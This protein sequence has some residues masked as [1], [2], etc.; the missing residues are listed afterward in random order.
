[1]SGELVT[2]YISVGTLLH[3]WPQVFKRISR[4]ERLQ[5]TRN[6]RVVASLSPPDRD[7]VLLDELAAAGEIDKGWRERQSQLLSLLP[8]LPGITSSAGPPVG[9]EAILADRNST[10]R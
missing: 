1:M 3:D 7:E 10:A 8:T 5:L 6:G 9:T 2:R 4:G